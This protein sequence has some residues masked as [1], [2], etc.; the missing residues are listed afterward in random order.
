MR[1]QPLVD[2]GIAVF[3]FFWGHVPRLKDGVPGVVERPVTV[4]EPA[5]RLH[6][7]E[8]RRGRIRGENVERGTLQP[9]FLDP[10]SG[11]G[12]HILAVVIESEDE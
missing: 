9:V 11:A 5:L 4:Q 2:P 1:E 6:L 12:E 3:E 7:T 8:Q 10:L